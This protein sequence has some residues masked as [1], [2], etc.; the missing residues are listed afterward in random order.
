M[1]WHLSP[2][3][4]ALGLGLA[5]GHVIWR[6]QFPAP[7]SHP[8]MAASTAWHKKTNHYTLSLNPSPKGRGTHNLATLRPLGEGAGG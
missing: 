1:L 3:G 2:W 6:H 4:I 8:P 5:E 7:I